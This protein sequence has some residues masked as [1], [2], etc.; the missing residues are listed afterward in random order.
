[1]RIAKP[2]LIVSTPIGV[3][4]GLHEAWRLA[5]GLVFLMAMLLVAVT[6]A[7]GSVVVVARREQRSE[8]ARAADAR[9]AVGSNAH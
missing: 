6:A 3:A 4:G 2:I 1:M 7:I 5:G 9:G 8:A